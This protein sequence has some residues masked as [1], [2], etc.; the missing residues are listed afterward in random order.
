MMDGIGFVYRIVTASYEFDN[1][2][3]LH[4]SPA[5]AFSESLKG[6]ADQ[7]A[8]ERTK[9]ARLCHQDR[10]NSSSRLLKS[11]RLQR[12]SQLVSEEDTIVLYM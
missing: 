1:G 2:I 3:S 6:T 5:R 8:T 11:T 10:L 9:G 7:S 4:L 12:R